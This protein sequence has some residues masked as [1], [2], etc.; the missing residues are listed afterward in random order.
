[1][2]RVTLPS[3]LKNLKTYEV[4]LTQTTEAD[5][6]SHFNGLF[7]LFEAGKDK[8][9]KRI[10]DVVGMFLDENPYANRDW[11]KHTPTRHYKESFAWFGEN[12]DEMT[13][14]FSFSNLFADL[15][16]IAKHYEWEELDDMK[17]EMEKFNTHIS[18]GQ[19]DLFQLESC[20]FLQAKKKFEEENKEWIEEQADMKKHKSEHP[21]GY[22]LRFQ[23]EEG[24]PIYLS[25]KYCKANYDKEI[26]MLRKHREYVK[27]TEPVAA[28]EVPVAPVEVKPY[29]KPVEQVCED[30]GFKSHHKSVFDYHKQ[31]P[32]HKKVIQL[33]GWY[34]PC[35][36]VQSRT[37]M[38]YKNHI[39]TKKHTKKANGETEYYCEKC[40]YKTL[41]KHLYDQHCE[42]KKHKEK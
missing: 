6:R 26:E 11:K 3:S 27:V 18:G 19:A 36:E 31:E 39:Q 14:Y 35:C 37:E 40:D 30:C 22:T 28:V 33:K 17:Y 25:C 32:E 13:E 4:L 5:L 15:N 1:M 21:T 10:S 8:Y 16:R 9:M 29:I 38:E 12:E 24:N 20:R 41:L 23:E 7:A 34:C 42:G 2:P